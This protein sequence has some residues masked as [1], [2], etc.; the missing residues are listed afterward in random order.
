MSAAVRI[1][2]ASM[3]FVRVG[4]S[5]SFWLVNAGLLILPF[6]KLSKRDEYHPLREEHFH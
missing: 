5:S 3:R 1:L 4:N 6:I 2:L